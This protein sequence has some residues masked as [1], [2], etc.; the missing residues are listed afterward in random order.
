MKTKMMWLYIIMGTLYWVPAL[1]PP[2]RVLISIIQPSGNHPS[3]SSIC[4]ARWIEWYGNTNKPRLRITWE[5]GKMKMSKLTETATD[6]SL[7]FLMVGME[8][9]TST[10]EWSLHPI[11]GSMQCYKNHEWVK[12]YLVLMKLANICLNFINYSAISFT[13]YII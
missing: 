12:P 5:Q 1:I 2:F 3:E 4:T 11:L 13:T 7:N 9:K 6:V 10:L 8:Q